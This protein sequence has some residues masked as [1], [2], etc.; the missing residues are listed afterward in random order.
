MTEFLL[1]RSLHHLLSDPA[2][3]WTTVSGKRL[4]IL[5]PGQINVHEGPDLLEMAV[6]VEGNIIVGNSEFHRRSSEWREH[7]HQ[8]DERYR[9]IL[10]HIVCED[11][12]EEKFGQE[13]LLVPESELQRISAEQDFLTPDTRSL[14]DELQHYA[15]LRLL[16]KT[17]EAKEELERYGL[18]K[19]AV[20][21][22]ADF[23]HRYNSRR[24]RP[25]YGTGDL[26]EIIL[27][28]QNSE[29]MKFLYA[30]SGGESRNFHQ[31][32]SR[33]LHQKISSEGLHLRREILLNAIL[34]LALALAHEEMRI[35]L[36]SWYWSTPALHSYGILRRKYPTLPQ[37]FLWQQQGMLEYM[38]E[39]GSKTQSV[40]ESI[41]RFGFAGMLS[42]Y[43]SASENL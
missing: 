4:Q 3:I 8:L 6:F 40:R 21:L 5:S 39:H 26:H 41:S 22:V 12:S 17:A 14:I 10:L 37:N 25:K 42:F 23:L 11:D 34:P 24:R 7:S 9:N 1:Q 15:L 38:R 43:R 33:L 27:H 36:F 16:R 28:L 29:L 30:L 20:E 2:R 31:E 18:E 13:T 32:M 35:Q 19:A